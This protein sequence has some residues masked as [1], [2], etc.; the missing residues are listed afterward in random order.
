MK[1]ILLQTMKYK[2]R[3]EIKE[4]EGYIFD[5]SIGTWVSITDKTYLIHSENFCG[6]GTKKMILK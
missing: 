2:K 5:N 3:K 1:H 4:P 6:L